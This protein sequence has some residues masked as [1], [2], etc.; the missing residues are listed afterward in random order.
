MQLFQACLHPP[1]LQMHRHELPSPMQFCQ[2][3][4]VLIGWAHYGKAKRDLLR[5]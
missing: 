2:Q 5:T 3:A 1:H 4:A